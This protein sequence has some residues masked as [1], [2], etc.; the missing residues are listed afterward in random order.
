MPNKASAIVFLSKIGI[1]AYVAS[2]GFSGFK[3]LRRFPS[4]MPQ[5]F[6]LGPTKTSFL[7]SSLIL[8]FR[9]IFKAHPPV[10]QIGRLGYL[11][12]YSL[13]TSIKQSSNALCA[14]AATS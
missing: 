2:I 4:A 10:M 12:K 13:A 8:V 6:G 7:S 14:V 9:I 3:F 1:P 11:L 5:S